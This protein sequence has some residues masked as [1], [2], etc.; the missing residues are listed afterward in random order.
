[1]I[2][3]V[4]YKEEFYSLPNLLTVQLESY[5]NFLQEDIEPDKRTDESLDGIFR[6]IFPILDLQN[7]Y[8]LEYLGYRV[9]KPKYNIE[10]CLQKNLTYS[11]SIFVKLRLKKVRPQTGIL[12]EEPI[13]QEV[14]FGEIPYMTE[15][16]TFIINGVER[17]VLSQIHRAPGVYFSITEKEA[18]IYTA[19]LVPYR[20]PWISFTIDG[21]KVIGMTISKR[22]KIP[23]NRLLRILGFEDYKSMIEAFLNPEEVSIDDP[24]LL[25][26][27]YV[28]ADDVVSQETGELI[29]QIVVEK[30]EFIRREVTEKLI[31][32][33]KKEGVRKI[34]VLNLQDPAVEAMIT[35][36]RQ[37]RL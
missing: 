2:T 27:N 28:L 23:I 11:C 20:G 21:S 36:F 31:E 7:R 32:D 22:R 5:K 33:F 14:Y 29:Y 19:L 13:E 3:R 35:T 12:E 18:K 16:G 37:D 25:T 1:M 30:G 8:I 26:G 15:K 10:E 6:E 9:E 17:V 34:K 24:K 4:G